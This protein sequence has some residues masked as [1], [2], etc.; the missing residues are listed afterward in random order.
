MQVNR[1]YE[2]EIDLRDLF[3]H[4]LY[5]WRSMIIGAMIGAL[6]LGTFQFIRITLIHREGKLTLE[7]KQYEIDL[8]EYYDSI[9][10]CKLNIETYQK[11]IS[12]KKEYKDNSVYFS[13]DSQNEWV[14]W[15]RYYIQMDQAVLDA[16]PESSTEDPADHVSALYISLL[17]NG[18]DEEEMFSLL[19]TGKIE[20]ISELVDI[21]SDNA[22]NT[23]TVQVIGNDREKVLQQLDYF[24]QRME[25]YCFERA[26]I[27]GKHT[28]TCVNEDVRTRVDG[29]L[30]EKQNEFNKTIKAYQDAVRDNQ[31]V[32]NE[33]EE[34]E[35]P[36]R[37]GAHIVKYAVIGFILAA[38]LLAV[39]YASHYIMES[40]VRSSSELT[41]RYGIPVYA[42]L[43]HTRARNS[44]RGF[45]GLLEAFEN[46]NKK[47]DNEMIIGNL[48]ALMVEKH[49]GQAVLLTGSL[50]ASKYEQL[51]QRLKK[52]IGNTVD[53]RM[54]ADFL[55]D[56]RVFSDIKKVESVILVEEKHVSCL[57]D[58]DREGSIL[59]ILNVNVIGCILL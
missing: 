37:P 48:E 25:G 34:G 38:F 15:K 53:I 20:Y 5:K 50:S 16:L 44:G 9:E 45:D 47:T 24:V 31:E 19:G 27:V 46:K 8:Q 17:R 3:F 21:W 39:V 56:S 10:N 12:E 14:A 1:N 11:M 35:E 4:I 28:L 22:S 36:V 29:E 33:L 32:L 52:D 23:L 51:Y 26:Q 41:N 54:K 58:L 6:L 2:P 55:V 13:F 42:E 7:E 40:K 57:R 30:S 18:L 59:D 43:V 49:G